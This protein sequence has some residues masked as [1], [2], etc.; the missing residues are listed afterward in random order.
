MND[1][2]GPA[3]SAPRVTHMVALCRTCGAQW[4]VRSESLE[5][6]KSCSFCGAPINRISITS[7][8]PNFEGDIIS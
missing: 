7:E 3:S 4:Q 8:R 5:D 2:C 6:A 1:M